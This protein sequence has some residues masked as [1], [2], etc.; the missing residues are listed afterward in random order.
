MPHQTSDRAGVYIKQ[1]TGYQAFIP[2]PLPPDPPLV[3]SPQLL[4][5]LSAADRAI[6]RLDSA[7]E[8]LP[9]PDLFI[10]MY[11]RKEAVYSSQIEG[12]QAS[13]TDLLEYEAGRV[14]RDN[15]EDTKEVSN[16]VAAMNFG[17]ER[18]AS[19]PLSSRLLKEIHAKLLEGVRGSEKDPGSF[20]RYQNWIGPTGGSMNDAVFIPPPHQDINKIMGELE[21]F[22]HDQNP[23]PPLLKCGLAHSQ[24]ETIHPFLDGNGRMG[25]LLITFLLC[26]QGTL[27]RPL[28]YLSYYFKKHRQEYYERLQAVRDQ[29][30]W[31]AWLLFFLNGVRDVAK[32]AMDKARKIQNLRDE[33]RQL[34]GGRSELAQKLLDLLFI[35]PVLDVKLASSH[36]ACS[37]QGANNVIKRFLENN[38]L[39]QKDISERY[40]FFIYK[41]YL[42]ILGE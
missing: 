34:V 28:L 13:L 1:L 27:K 41:D 29:G 37:Y 8:L 24:F 25:R 4:D 32:E 17:L 38:L 35:N 36:L 22:L 23:L 31:E 14:R 6:G 21:S 9:N 7:T 11:V 39:Y 10:R 40:R 42:D 2:K 16:Y 5:M 30:S 20:R 33:H 18:L 3:L 19:L 26:W 15:P 12:T